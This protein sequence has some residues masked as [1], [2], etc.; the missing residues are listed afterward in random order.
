MTLK[1]YLKIAVA[2]SLFAVIIAAGAAVILP[3]LLELD[4]HR[5]E[6]LSM[7]EKALNRRVSYQTASLSWQFAP[8]IV[9]RGI[10]IAEK[11]GDSNFLEMERLAFKIALLPLLGKEVRLREVVVERPVLLLERDHKG[12]FNFHDLMTAKS[13]G[14]EIQL[15][16]VRIKDGLVRFT[17]RL[18][19]PQGFITSL[20]KV[21]LYLSSLDKGNTSELRLSG[22]L[23]GGSG[24]GQL[25]VSGTVRLPAEQES[26]NEAKLDLRLSAKNLDVGRYWPYYGHY[27]PCEPLRGVLDSELAFAGRL[28]EFTS[29]GQFRVKSLFFHYPEVFHAI[30]TPKELSI[31]FDVERSSRN[32]AIKSFD[33]NIDGLNVKG[34]C[35]LDDMDTKDPHI[36]AR[37]AIA[38]F[39][40]E[41]FRQYI[42]YGVIPKGTAD[43]IE[44]Q[45][46]G[47]IFTL[48][49]GKL[50]GRLSRIRHMESGDNYNALLVRARVEQGLIALGP[51][52]P[53]FSNI[54]GTLE[55]RG[56]DFSLRGMSGNFGGAPFNLEGKIADYPLATPASYPF[57]MEIAPGE[58]EVAWLFRQDKPSGLSFNGRSLLR[59]SGAGTAS[60]YRLSGTWELSGAEYRYQQ[61]LHKPAGIANRLRFNARLGETEAQLTDL[62]YELPPLDVAATAAYRYGEPAAL[63]FA[64]NTNLFMADQVA[65]VLPGLQDYHPAGRLQAALSGAGDPVAPDAVRVKGTIE[66]DNFSLRPF[67][68]I[69]PLN[70]VSGTIKVTEA[71]LQTE[72]L[73]GRV[74]ESAFAVKGR[75]TGRTSPVAALY[76]SSPQL[77]PEDF[78]YQASGQAPEVKNVAGSISL[79]EGR[80]TIASL[81]AQVNRSQFVA[82][83]EVVD[84]AGSRLSLRVDFPY[85]WMEDMEALAGLKRAG[86]AEGQPQDFTLQ[87]EVSA[88][89]G[90]FRE[91]P[92]EHLAASLSVQK[93]EMAIKSLGVGLFGG[94]VSASGRADFAGNGGAQYQAQYRLDRVDAAQLLIVAGVGPSVTGQLTAAGEVTMRGDNPAELKKSA[95]VAVHLHLHDGSINNPGKTGEKI[96]YSIID[97]DLAF[98][99][100][101]LTVQGLNAVVL[102]GS[103]SG[104]GTA[105]LDSVGGPSFQ[106]QYRLDRV[107]AAHLLKAA[108]VEPSVTGVLTAAGEL[109]A[110]GNSTEDLKKSVRVTADIEL[111]SGSLFFAATAG[112]DQRSEVPFKA[113]QGRISFEKSLLTAQ[114]VRIDIFDGTV[115]ANGAADFIVPAQPGY[116]ASFHIESIDAAQV[117]AAFGFR[118]DFTGR[119]GLDGEFAASGDN[120]DALRKS[121]QGSFEI[122]FKNGVINKFGFVSKIF[123][124]LNVSQLFALRL[125]DMV[126]V[127]MP[128]D[129]I[130]GSFFVKDGIF[131]TSDLALDSPSINLTVVGKTDIVKQ[132]IDLLCAVQPLQTLSM[133]ISRIPVIGWLLTGGSKRFLVT[134][135]EAKGRWTDPTVTGRNI[136]EL[137]GGVYNIFKRVYNLP[138]NLFTNTG[139]V[140]M[141]N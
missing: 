96:P 56:K 41:E 55:L 60:D 88:A 115:F 37:A 46:Q 42:P 77:Q 89:A 10:T 12:A 81:A 35:S 93:G 48:E 69:K 53:A 92:F 75:L 31:A 72:R 102:G 62:H 80:L 45:L 104:S 135:Y 107:D 30:L 20:E 66:L 106:V 73:T 86:K 19:D 120:P 84:G 24:Q 133:V 103:V 138:E 119:L 126:S 79:Q 90:S 67:A 51:Q 139:K 6:I 52:V 50:D 114:S 8:A 16:A 122:H 7:A 110:R 43:F 113:V 34:S 2:V 74:G 54:K 65:A 124:V 130:D 129:S 140:F 116:Q 32:L 15:Q 44:Q 78:G 61:L 128:Y 101:I 100:G 108:G 94:T 76:F 83:G 111:N 123:S 27:L 3:R 1:T 63:T 91:I 137:P 131:S 132:E 95:A 68:R 5:A 127:G 70:S 121:V 33:L 25:S 40:L 97:A 64:A 98:N 58:A 82:S 29:K 4:S 39:R 87:A 118:S 47:G 134:Y 21:D 22:L 49:E 14:F 57:T 85:L 28:Q 9:F 71:D 23:A 136:S 99:K 117:D 13:S 36:E 125:P 38:P 109:T 26:L 112:K 11:S 59:L 17:D 18:Q 141:G 105:E